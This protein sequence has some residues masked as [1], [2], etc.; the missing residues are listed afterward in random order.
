MYSSVLQFAGEIRVVPDEVRGGRQLVRS[1]QNRQLGLVD[2]QRLPAAVA[3]NDAC[4]ID[5]CA[6]PSFDLFKVIGSEL[7]AHRPSGND[8]VDA[9]AWRRMDVY[10]FQCA[11]DGPDRLY[12]RHAKSL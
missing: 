11:G 9:E 4:D 5:A 1:R 6:E 8:V 3:V 12:C 2:P 7:A 10:R